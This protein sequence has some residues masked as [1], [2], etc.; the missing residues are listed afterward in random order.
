VQDWY[1]PFNE[2]HDDPPASAW[3]FNPEARC[4]VHGSSNAINNALMIE[5]HANFNVGLGFETLTS[6]S[7]IANWPRTTTSAANQGKIG[8]FSS[9]YI[10]YDI[11]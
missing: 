2:G 10:I 7:G 6:R 9:V 1:I 8:L 4:T 11:S 5:R 3:P